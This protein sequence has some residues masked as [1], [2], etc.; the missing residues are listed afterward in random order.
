[1][2]S[3]L[4]QSNISVSNVIASKTNCSQRET[5]RERDR[6]T[7]RDRD[8]QKEGRERGRERRERS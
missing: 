3:N 1:M 2:S 6:D 5:E 8:R 7:E 4:L